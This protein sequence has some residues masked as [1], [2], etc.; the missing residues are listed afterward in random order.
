MNK[1]YVRRPCKCA[2]VYFVQHTAYNKWFQYFTY[3][4]CFINSVFITTEPQV[5]KDDINRV[6][7]TRSKQS[8]K[9]ILQ[10]PMM[11]FIKY[12]IIYYL[13]YKKNI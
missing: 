4:Y 11:S 8:F 12:F 9:V 3:K 6:L 10:V 2:V 7:K 1:L 5:I 13:L